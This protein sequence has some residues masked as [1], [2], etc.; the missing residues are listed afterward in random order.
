MAD[1]PETCLVD[2]REHRLE[3]EEVLRLLGH[4]RM[5]S[6]AEGELRTMDASAERA[7]D[8]AAPLP[9]GPLDEHGRVRLAPG[10]AARLLHSDEAC[11]EAWLRAREL[12]L[13]GVGDR[14]AFEAEVRMLASAGCDLVAT[15]QAQRHAAAMQADGAKF[16]TLGAPSTPYDGALAHAQAHPG[17]PPPSDDVFLLMQRVARALDQEEGRTPGWDV[18]RR[19]ELRSLAAGVDE[20]RGRWETVRDPRA[21]ATPAMI[22]VMH[23]MEALVTHARSLGLDVPAEGARRLGS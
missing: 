2:V 7:A 10:E 1:A 16:R 22:A 6:V 5:L 18:N 15:L 9:D 17:T 21:P 12:G 3:V 20:Q 14:T 8:D 13:D 19:T 11:T 4:P 23:G